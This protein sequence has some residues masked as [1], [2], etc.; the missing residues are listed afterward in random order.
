M[1]NRLM[2]FSALARSIFCVLSCTCSRTLGDGGITGSVRLTGMSGK[3]WAKGA[4]G[5]LAQHTLHHHAG[6]QTPAQ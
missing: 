2:H 6:L 4:H 3:L 5:H 1:A